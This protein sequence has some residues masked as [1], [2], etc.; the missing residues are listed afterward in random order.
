MRSMKRMLAV[1]LATLST[2]LFAD[3]RDLAR[4]AGCNIC[5]ADRIRLAA[6]SWVEI[7]ERYRGDSAAAEALFERTRS[8]STA[9]ETRWGGAPKLGVDAGTIGDAELRA[10]IDWVL[11]FGDRA[12]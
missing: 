6:P 5:H 4:D 12:P 1:A 3:A 7:A 9:G 2:S 11:A 8:G 10:V